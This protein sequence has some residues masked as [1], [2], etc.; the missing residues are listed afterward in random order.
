MCGNRPR[1]VEETQDGGIGLACVGKPIYDPSL[2]NGG[3][4][5]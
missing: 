2:P 3:H 5:Y 1:A 4:W